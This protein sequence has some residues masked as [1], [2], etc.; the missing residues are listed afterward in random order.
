[1]RKFVIAAL[2]LAAGGA[3]AQSQMKPGLWEITQQTKTASGQMEQHMAQ[4]QQQMANMPP[5]Q[6]KMV[7]QMMAQ[8]GMKMGTAG[9]NGMT[10]KIC[11]TKEMIE[12]N[13]MPQQQRGDCKT[14]LQPSVGN[15]KKMSFTCTNPPSSGEGEYTLT[16][17]D[18]YHM[19]MVVN[20]QVQGKPETM[21]M[22]GS[23]KW[24]GADCGDIKPI[25]PP[26]A[27]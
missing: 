8:R 10:M 12:R 24:L 23:G 26:A 20:T 2:A 27:K 6:R 22:E 1:M 17:A 25:R 19:K 14:T 5:E 3:F 13:Q 4:M 15:T 11:M 16:S 21:N 18:S 7:E 9:G